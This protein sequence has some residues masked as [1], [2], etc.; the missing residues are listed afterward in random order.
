MPDA[1]GSLEAAIRSACRLRHYALRTEAAY[2]SWARRYCRFHRDPHGRPRHPRT[3][4]EPDVVAF[5]PYLA[6]DRNVAASTQNQ[7]LAALLFLYDA[8]LALPLADLKPI[9]NG[10]AL[11][12]HNAVRVCHSVVRVPHNV[13][14]VCHNG[15]RVP[16]GGA[17]VAHNASR[18]VHDAIRASPD[19][20]PAAH[21][22]SRTAHGASR[23]DAPGTSALQAASSRGKTAAPLIE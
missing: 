22:A 12:P 16:H 8:V 4:A 6:E 19:A 5:L 7:A 13:V 3:L 18:A 10:V 15:N 11:V 23:A 17:W 21:S 9:P 2:V 1:P 20:P 14:R